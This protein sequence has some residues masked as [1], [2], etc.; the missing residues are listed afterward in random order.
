MSV[1]RCLLLLLL[2]VSLSCEAKETPSPKQLQALYHSLSSTSVQQMLAF[3][4]L[5]PDSQE[6]KKALQ[7]G[8]ELLA[9]RPSNSSN[10]SLVLPP[11][12]LMSAVLE[13]INKPKDT[14]T[15]ALQEQEL[16]IIQRLAVRLPNRKLKGC[17]ARRL[18]ELLD[19]PPDEID[20]SRALLL[21]QFDDNLPAVNSYEALIDLMALQLLAALPLETTPAIKIDAI[22]KMIFSEM[23]FRFPPHSLYAK[24]IDLYTFLPSV[25]DSRRGV[26]L[27]V[28]LLYLCLAQRMG[29]QLEIITPPG[30]IFVSYRQGGQ[31]INIETTARGIPLPDEVYLGL[32]TRSLQRRNLKE[33][34]GLIFFNQAS[35]YW[36][37]EEYAR[38]VDTYHKALPFLPDDPLLKEFLGYQYLFLGKIKEGKALLEQVKDH[39]PEYNVSKNSLPQEYLSGKVDVDS[40]K[41]LFLPVDETRESILKKQQALLNAVNQWPYFQSGLFALAICYLQLHQEKEAIKTLEKF[42]LLNPDDASAEY[43]LAAL[44]AERRNFNKS[45]EHL[46]QAETIVSLRDH[47]PKALNTLRKTLTLASPE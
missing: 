28:S 45:W 7:R 29:L 35:V 39:L 32:E 30:H 25:L 44:Y 38:A 1:E 36:Q 34:V 40:L 21:S 2:L 22:N 19:L 8:W 10:S 27:G 17:Q 42:H 43:Y 18:G 37:H 13:L 24:E 3:Y 9:G 41:A 20:L 11:P 15:P 12:S 6:G 46:H 4:E 16:A 47:H 14:P 5:Y 31:I 26:C 33:T 23:G